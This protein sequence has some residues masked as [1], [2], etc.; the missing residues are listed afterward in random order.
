MISIW[1]RLLL[2]QFGINM[3]RVC[4]CPILKNTKSEFYSRLQITICWWCLSLILR[5]NEFFAR[6]NRPPRRCEQINLFFWNFYDECF[7]AHDYDRLLHGYKFVWQENWYDNS[8]SLQRTLQWSE[9]DCDVFTWISL[10]N[11]ERRCIQNCERENFEYRNTWCE[12]FR[13]V[14]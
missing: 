8:S 1:K 4:I 14:C 10:T 7:E 9:I 3:F 13:Y 12:Y 5:R 11:Q 2:N 6:T